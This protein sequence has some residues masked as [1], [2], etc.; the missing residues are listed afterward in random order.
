MLVI[1]TNSL[2]RPVLT[3]VTANLERIIQSRK[4]CL[5]I[6]AI[7]DI[8]ITHHRRS[9]NRA[10]ADAA[11]LVEVLNRETTRAAPHAPD[12]DKGRDFE[13]NVGMLGIKTPERVPYLAARGLPHQ[14]P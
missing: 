5:P 4:H 12:I 3:A 2:M 11:H 10:D 14:P 9:G 13:I 8:D 6:A 7:T 1:R